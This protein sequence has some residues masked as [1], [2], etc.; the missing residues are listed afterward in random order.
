MWAHN[1]I[2]MS[3]PGSSAGHMPPPGAGAMPAPYPGQ[4]NPPGMNPAMTGY[5]GGQMQL[6]YGQLEGNQHMYDQRMA[7]ANR[8][9][10]VAAAQA[11]AAGRPP[12]GMMPDYTQ[13]PMGQNP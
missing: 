2:P 1:G 10:A 7:A 9:A 5:P 12:Q 13:M 4:M 6:P 11:Q 3:Q 8:A